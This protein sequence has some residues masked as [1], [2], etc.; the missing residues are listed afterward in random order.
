MNR[1][2][3]KSM[4][5]VRA[6]IVMAVVMFSGALAAVMA[7]Q[8]RTRR[9]V[10]AADAAGKFRPARR[11]NRTRSRHRRRCSR[12]GKSSTPANVRSVTARPARATVPTPIPTSR[13]KT[14]PTASR[15]ARNPD[16]VMYLQGLERPEVAEDDGDEDR[17][18]VEGRRVDRRPLREVPP[19]VIRALPSEVGG[20]DCSGQPLSLELSNPGSALRTR[21]RRREACS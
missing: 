14:S 5:M 20:C 11:R 19:E 16:G 8:H 12:R 10:D 13:P 1:N 9:R 17:R 15:A 7:S 3:G 4:R 18:M 21:R 2:G 6:V